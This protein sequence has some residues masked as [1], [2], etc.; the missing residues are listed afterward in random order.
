MKE[1]K[2]YIKEITWYIKEMPFYI[3]ENAP[4]SEEMTV[5]IRRAAWNEMLLATLSFGESLSRTCFGRLGVRP[6][7][8]C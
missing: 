3:K 6:N 1:M 2:W 8:C 5:Y 4:Y 7:E